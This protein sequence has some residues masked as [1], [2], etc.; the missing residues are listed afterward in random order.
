MLR[1]F[2]I[3]MVLSGLAF[4]ASYSWWFFFPEKT[5]T[6]S[7]MPQTSEQAGAETGAKAGKTMT[8]TFKVP[9]QRQTLATAL[10]LLASIVSI[11]GTLISTWLTLRA[12]RRKANA[13]EKP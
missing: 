11:F 1:F 9:S 12:E 2:V 6:L 5:V 13:R 3:A 7:V 4:A 10:S 8:R